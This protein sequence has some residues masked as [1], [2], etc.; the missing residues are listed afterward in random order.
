MDREMI[1]TI[2]AATAECGM[3]QL[4]NWLPAERHAELRELLFDLTIGAI[5]AVS[6]AR[7]GWH[8]SPPGANRGSEPW[9]GTMTA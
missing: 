2:A 4:A 6:D 8:L 7:R 1:E 5:C 9:K 3:Q